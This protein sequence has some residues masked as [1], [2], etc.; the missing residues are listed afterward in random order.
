M[1]WE[2]IYSS[3]QGRLGGALSSMIQQI[4]IA[5]KKERYVRIQLDNPKFDA[6]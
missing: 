5:V 1:N 6:R 4:K 3:L 2:R